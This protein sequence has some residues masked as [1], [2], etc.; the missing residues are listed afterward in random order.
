MFLAIREKLNREDKGFTLIELMVVVL[1]IAILI[2]IAIPTFLGARKKA[3]DRATQADLRQALLTAKSYYTDQE[4]YGAADAATATAY[5][6]L[7]PSLDFD[8]AAPT[9]AAKKVFIT[10]ASGTEVTLVAYSKSDKW[11]CI[12]ESSSG[13]TKFG[14]TS[15]VGGTVNNPYTSYA[16]CQGGW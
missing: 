11:V 10:S 9:R 6:G 2:A 14:E 7:E 16:T 5:E 12:S 3:Q 15:T 8:H 4:T 1:I 13:Q